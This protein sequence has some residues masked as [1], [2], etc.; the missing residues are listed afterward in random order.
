M[1]LYETVNVIFWI[2]YFIYFYPKFTSRYFKKKPVKKLIWNFTILINLIQFL[3]I[4]LNLNFDFRN[5][6]Y[7]RYIL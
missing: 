6:Y 7:I 5:N 4:E 3:N 2:I 1:R